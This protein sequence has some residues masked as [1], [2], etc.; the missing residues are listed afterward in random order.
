V[1]VVTHSL[2]RFHSSRY[3]VSIVVPIFYN[4]TPS[5]I[6][7]YTVVDRT[8]SHYVPGVLRYLPPIPLPVYRSLHRTTAHRLHY[9]ISICISF[10]FISCL[11]HHHSMF[12][13]YAIP[14]RDSLLRSLPTTRWSTGTVRSY[15]F[16]YRFFYFYLLIPFI[17]IPV[18]LRSTYRY[19]I[20]S[21]FSIPFVFILLPFYSYITITYRFH[22][23]DT[24][25]LQFHSI[26]CDTYIPFITAPC[27]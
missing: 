13:P 12:I 16:R 20:Q 17:P 5:A 26:R 3:S 8:V 24:H 15:R 2:P 1:D 4:C 25:R 6:C 9:L 19:Q 10:S 14:F 11:L 22:S 21:A 18:L 7:S 23:I 27:D